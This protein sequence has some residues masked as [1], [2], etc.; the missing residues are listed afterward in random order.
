MTITIAT[1]ILTIQ[2]IT[3]YPTPMTGRFGISQYPA[4]FSFLRFQ[5]FEMMFQGLDLLL[6]TGELRFCGIFHLG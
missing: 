6:E 2:T 5:D 3:M 4:N 1:K